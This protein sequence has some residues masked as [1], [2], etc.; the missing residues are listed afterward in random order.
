VRVP[1]WTGVLEDRELHIFADVSEKAYAAAVYLKGLGR[2]G[3]WRSSLLIAKMKVA[4]FK[5][6]SAPRF[7]L[8]GALLAAQLL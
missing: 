8:R 3:K 5:L 6:R 2:S 7:E 1:R 4:P